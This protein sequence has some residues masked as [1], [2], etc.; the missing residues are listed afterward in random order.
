MKRIHL[1]YL[2]ASITLFSSCSG[3][4]SK[5]PA[6]NTSAEIDKNKNTKDTIN[7]SRGSGSQWIYTETVCQIDDI[8]TYL[9]ETW[10]EDELFFSYPYKGSTP[11]KLILRKISSQDISEVFLLIQKDQFLFNNND[12]F[13]KVRFDNE[14]AQTFQFS[15]SKEFSSTTISIHHSTAFISKLKK[16]KTLLAQFE[17]FHEENKSVKF[18]IEGLNWPY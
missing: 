15:A 16:T 3:L 13:I 5:P 9:A 7:E 6:Q 10:S 2:F 14:K 1:F 17:F 4:S 11:V 8:K 12:D 18:N